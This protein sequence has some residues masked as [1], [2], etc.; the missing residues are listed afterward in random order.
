MTSNETLISFHGDPAIKE[1]Y[2]NRLKEHRRL[3]HLTQ[4][5]GWE[6]GKG[7]AIGCT[8]EAYDH[9]L[10]RTKL[11][12]PMWLARLIDNIFEGLRKE[13]AE[14]FAE[15]VLEAIPVGVCVE[16]VKHEIA[17]KR[18]TALLDTLEGNL[19]EYAI[20][21]RVAIRKV[22][23]WHKNPTEDATS[24][25]QAAWQAE[26]AAQHTAILADRSAKKATTDADIF[27]A[28]SA[29]IAAW[30]TQYAAECAARSASDN[31]SCS[32]LCAIES[33]ICGT[34]YADFAKQAAW[35]V[36]AENLIQSLKDCK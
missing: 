33:A 13:R 15:D 4:G 20:M 30:R 36:E 17:I 23:K 11:G 12:L 1:K 22:I 29:E 2:V 19:E 6:N 10:F 26:G 8:L 3:E 16:H 9:S 28:R 5:V 27:A 34:P 7:C 35:R 25:K 21:A 14:Q 32:V 18:L 24:A 31:I